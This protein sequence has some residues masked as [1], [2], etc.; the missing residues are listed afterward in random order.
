VQVTL[1]R[2]G[3]LTGTTTANYVTRNATATQRG[4]FTFAAGSVTFA[5]NETTKT[6][7]VLVSED[8]Y[9]ET[10]E[11]ALLQISS[12]TGGAPGNRSSATLRIDD[13]ETA[14]GPNEIDNTA[15]FVCQNYHDF[16]NRQSD[17]AGQA[18]WEGVIN[19]CGGNAACVDNR[20]WNVAQAFFL[21]T[22]FQNTGYF[23]FRLYRASFVDSG[24][25]PRGLPRYAEFL[26]DTQEVGRGV[27]VGQPGADQQLEANKQA[28]ALA[29]VNRADFK[30]EFP[31]TMTR[32]EFVNQLFARAETTPTTEERNQ[33]NAAYD[34]AGSLAEKR[35][36][37]LRAVVET[38]SVYNKQYNSASVLMM[39]F[40]F[41]RR[42]PNDA[43]DNSFVGLDFWL[44]KMNEHSL[45]GEDM[46]N[47][48]QA[49]ARLG[50]AEM[51]RAF[52]ISQEYRRRFG[53]SGPPDDR[54]NDPNPSPVAAIG[55]WPD[56]P[57]GTLF[58]M[59]RAMKLNDG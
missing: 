57:F 11:T 40:G 9:D 5:P 49:R 29:W 32:D 12:V 19:E 33:A 35:A 47:E 22:E 15:S 27:V 7:I 55:A 1:V 31:E 42:N 18:F 54:G 8:S 53:L 16:L 56:L 17:A 39:Y 25:R 48:E 37:A 20:R 50:R 59:A 3:T 30:A 41:L 44:G 6:F 4:D 28:F 13:D 52:I 21:S 26:R 2:S 51:I 43:P 23:V 38:G 45:A 24:Q 46:R 58:D 34:A 36:R 14:D 10:D